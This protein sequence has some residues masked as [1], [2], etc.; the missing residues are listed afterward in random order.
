MPELHEGFLHT[1][2]RRPRSSHTEIRS[3]KDPEALFK[4]SEL[5]FSSQGAIIRC[6]GLWGSHQSEWWAETEFQDSQ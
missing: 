4:N 5:L 3:P 2:A 1:H 6:G